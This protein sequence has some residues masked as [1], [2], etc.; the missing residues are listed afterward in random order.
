M[1]SQVHSINTICK[2]C[3]SNSLASSANPTARSLSASIS[4]TS[5]ALLRPS[6]LD[7][8]MPSTAI[9]RGF[10]SHIRDA[11]VFEVLGADRGCWLRR[12]MSGH[13]PIAT[14]AAGRKLGG[15]L[16]MPCKRSM[17][18]GG[19]GRTMMLSCRGDGVERCCRGR[20][21]PLSRELVDRG[22]LR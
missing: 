15:L 7:T 11:V 22:V 16:V 5:H 1:Q 9:T 14:A 12:A 3:C 4:V 19:L 8:P 20:V 17:G 2:T 6:P 13:V 10:S 21:V 18:S